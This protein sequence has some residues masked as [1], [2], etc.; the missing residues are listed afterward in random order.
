MNKQLQEILSQSKNI[1]IVGHIN[2]DGDCFGSICA[3]FDY[4][5]DTFN[6]TVDCFAECENVA[7]DLKPFIN[8][9]TFNPN[10]KPHYDTCICVDTA[11]LNRLGKY[12]EVFNN[13][14]NTICIDHHAT[15]I[16]F[17][18]INLITLRS[19]NCENVY[20]LLKDLGY[21]CKVSTLGKLCAGILTDTLNLS[22]ASVDHQTFLAMAEIQQAG[23]DIC[24][25]R[26]HFFGGNS[27]VQFRLLSLA[28][29]SA[30]FY[31]NNTI[32]SMEITE[33]QMDEIGATQEDLNPII[34]QAF[35]MKDALCAF[36]ITPRNN[37]I[38][39]SFRARDGIDVSIIAGHFGG[40]GHKPAAAFTSPNITSED[41]NYII[42]NLINQINLLPPKNNKI[43]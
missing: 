14:T 8:N 20:Y 23:V 37:Q 2:P 9:V 16:G 11:D 43:F 36:L 4:I 7:E 21:K 28:M 22:T 41:I 18:K 15:N 10:P 3:M 26:Q 24:K 13:S 42:D 27:L 38:H 19:S 17:A 34:S 5:T 30:Q 29:N 6:S 1:A 35:C 25:I 32:M 39:I 12:D 40:G 31:H 33:Q